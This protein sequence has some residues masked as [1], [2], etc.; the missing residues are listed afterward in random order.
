ME[1]IGAAFERRTRV[2]VPEW[3]DEDGEPTV[4]YAQPFTIHDD[5]ALH[6]FVKDDD[7]AGF[8]DVIIHKAENSAGDKLFDKGDKPKILRRAKAHV[9]KRVALQIMASES[10]EDAEGN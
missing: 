6:R 3:P 7:P 1:R 9:I 5:R 2:E 10:L 8:V 4:I